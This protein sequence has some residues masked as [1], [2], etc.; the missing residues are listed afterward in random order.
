MYIL[1]V[2]SFLRTKIVLNQAVGIT[3]IVKHMHRGGLP[4]TS[5]PSRG[6]RVSPVPE[7]RKESL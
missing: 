5:I 4:W 3:V 7:L 2:T 1:A 6:D